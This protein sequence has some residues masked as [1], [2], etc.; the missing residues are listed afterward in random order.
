[1]MASVFNHPTYQHMVNTNKTK[2]FRQ[3]DLSNQLD[4]QLLGNSMCISDIMKRMSP[5]VSKHLLSAKSPMHA[6]N[7]SLMLDE[8][9]PRHQ[10]STNRSPRRNKNDQ[11]KP[12]VLRNKTPYAQ[13][14][15]GILSPQHYHCGEETNTLRLSKAYTLPHNKDTDVLETLP[16]GDSSINGTEEDQGVRSPLSN[17]VLHLLNKICLQSILGDFISSLQH[18]GS[19]YRRSG[20]MQILTSARCR[21]MP[22]PG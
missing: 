22:C 10:N 20:L 14:N 8:F 3:S 18:V 19:S 6:I 15:P 5:E 2:S 16:T 13:L 21:P 9:L 7:W 1:M 11:Y 12:V 17:K 4:H